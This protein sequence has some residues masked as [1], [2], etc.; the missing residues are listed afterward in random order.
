[1]I[2][3]H[4]ERLER[5][6]SVASLPWA[7]PLSPETLSKRIYTQPVRQPASTLMRIRTHSNY[8]SFILKFLDDDSS[9]WGLFKR[10][11]FLRKNIRE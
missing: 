5:D 3:V 10:S 7:P 8:L 1:M 2:I 6:F 11:G 9:I 4:L